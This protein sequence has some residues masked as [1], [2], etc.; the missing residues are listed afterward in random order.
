MAAASA[1]ESDLDIDML[2]ESVRRMLDADAADWDALVAMGLPMLCGDGGGRLEDVVH[3]LPE[4]GRR[5]STLPLIETVLL[6]LFAPGLIAPDRRIAICFDEAGRGGP[7]VERHRVSGT[8]RLVEGAASAEMLAVF[9]AAGRLLAIDVADEG[10]TIAPTAAL[11]GDLC[12][13]VL[14]SAAIVAVHEL[15]DRVDAMLEVARLCLCARALGAAQRG[16]ELANDYAKVRK[17]FGKAIGSFQAIQHKLANSHI[18]LSACGLQL[19]AAARAFDNRN[20]QWPNLVAAAVAFASPSLRRVA[21]ETQHAFG[22]I[23]FAEEHQ[24]PALFRRVHGD[25][26]RLGGGMAAS[27]RLGAAMVGDNEGALAA[28]LADES[29]PAAAFRA[30]LRLWLSENWTDADR[31]ALGARPFNE[32]DWDMGFLA[33]LGRD[34]WTTLNWPEE[35]GGMAATPFEQ[36]AF[37]E[38]LQKAGAPE[39][40]MIC[41]CRIVAPEIIAHGSEQLRADLLPKL[42]AGAVTGC[43]GYSE[44]EAG[45]DLASLRT[46]AIHD[47]DDYVIDG[48]KIWTTDGQRASHMILAARTDPDRESRHGGISLFILPMDTPGITV[49][50]MTGLHGHVFCNIFFDAVR[51]PAHHRLGAE[52]QGWAILGNALANER[53]TMGGFTSRLAVLLDGVIAALHA[54]PALSSD[55]SVH[56]SVGKLVGK[57]VAGRMLAVDSIAQMAQGRTPLVEAAMAKVFASELAQEICEEALDLLGGVALLGADAPG[58]PADGLIE[59]FLRL[60]IMYVVGGGSNEIQRSLVAG[61]GLGL[62]R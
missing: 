52:G 2:T 12:D 25:C 56:V 28:L 60:S 10:V 22:A 39:H 5:A 8:L 13:V 4:F 62:G 16:F 45:S 41:P 55:P 37:T 59:E 53:I 30:R 1:T 58:A 43:L 21:L 29:D 23:G 61:R 49:R 57:L 32:R 36:L 18:A 11:A 6:N 3:I 47:G 48:Q 42:R 15:G 44:P 19:R 17:Q 7:S 40:A 9:D 20:P 31:D 51:L 14:D 34:G 33:R 26:V 46:L 35:A 50:T 38:E 27:A 54:D 24:A